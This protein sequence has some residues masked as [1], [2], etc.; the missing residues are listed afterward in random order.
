MPD[1]IT[2]TRHLADV[3]KDGGPGAILGFGVGLY[4]TLPHGCGDAVNTVT[5]C[6]NRIGQDFMITNGVPLTFEWLFP[7]FLFT[8][9]GAAIGWL[10]IQVF[11][12]GNA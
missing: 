7:L 11:R 2:E 8:C 10:V 12:S 9:A 5:E 6:S 1:P 4:M 3:L